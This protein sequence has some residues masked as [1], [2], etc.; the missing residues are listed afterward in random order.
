MAH[1][2]EH[3][4]WTKHW[5]QVI[6]TYEWIVDAVERNGGRQL[7]RIGRAY[8]ADCGLH[9]DWRYWVGKVIVMQVLLYADTG[10]FLHP[11]RRKM[12]K[13]WRTQGEVYEMIA[14]H[15]EMMKKWTY[16]FE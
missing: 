4:D 16:G 12:K 3:L 6:P 15:E 8:M 14:Y 2:R 13:D 1:I 5:I 7:L 11:T 9:D 10:L